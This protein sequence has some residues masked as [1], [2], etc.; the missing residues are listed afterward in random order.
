MT[1]VGSGGAVAAVDCGTNST[2]LLVVDGSGKVLD[3]QMRITRLGEAVD[4]TGELAPEAIARTVEVLR[5]YRTIIDAKDVRRVRVVA[6]SATRDAGNSEEF[7]TAAERAIGSRPELLSGLEEGRL[8]FEGATARLPARMH[9]ENV[10][11]VA[12]IGGGSTELIAGPDRGDR[13]DDVTA[14]SLDIGC[15]RVSERFLH[16]D[17]PSDAE[18]QSAR[19]FIGELLRDALNRLPALAPGG[20]VIGLAGTV[21]TIA[22]MEVGAP[23]YE[24]DL[25]HH[26][27]LGRERVAFWLKVLAE[28]RSAERLR[29]RGMVRGR[30]DV[31]VGGVLVLHEIMDVFGCSEC[32]VSEDD[33][34]DGLV[35]SLRPAA[36]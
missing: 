27:L 6:T 4:A 34:L 19:L 1:K 18:I 15:V 32:L 26:V 35:M 20:V 8:S 16:H 3:R 17:P 12:D 5:H 10:L 9:R 23:R 24:R 13:V 28:E 21:S 25:V 22:S 33:I 2:R 36:A 7:F 29:H 11:L 14:V 31:I 30:E